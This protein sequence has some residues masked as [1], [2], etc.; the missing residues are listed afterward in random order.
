M[1]RYSEQQRAELP[2]LDPILVTLDSVKPE[3][4]AQ[5]NT[6]QLVID[7]RLPE[8]FGGGT[9]RDWVGLSVNV[10][11]QTGKV[12]KLRSML[13]AIAGEPEQ[14]RIIWVDDGLDPASGQIQGPVQWS[15]DGQPY[16]A[17]TEGL[18]VIIRGKTIHKESGDVWRIQHYQPVKKEPPPASR[19]RQPRQ[20]APP[21]PS[22]PEAPDP[23]E[24]WDPDE[25]PF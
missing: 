4:S 21:E 18:P 14:K 12:A 25:I 6:P 5:F 10:S 11:P 20:P 1:T 15:Y 8:E 2:E 9:L 19:Q 17:L 16:G 13:N 23:D 24:G 7:W 22:Q 3:I